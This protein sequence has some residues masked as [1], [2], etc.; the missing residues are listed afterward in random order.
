MCIRGLDRQE[1]DK[2]VFFGSKCDPGQKHNLSSDDVWVGLSGKKGWK[3]NGLDVFEDDTGLTLNNSFCI[4]WLLSWDNE[5]EMDGSKSGDGETFGLK[6][7]IGTW[8]LKVLESNKEEISCEIDGWKALLKTFELYG[9]YEAIGNGK[10]SNGS[11]VVF[12]IWFCWDKGKIEDDT[13]P[14]SKPTSGSSGWMISLLE[15]LKGKIVSRNRTC[16]LI[17]TLLVSL[18]RQRYPFALEA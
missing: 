11:C 14:G 4:R 8:V 15:V 9:W 10:T 18:S 16:L 5:V 6:D 13:D 7:D 17:N 12:F 1:V 3:S 2:V